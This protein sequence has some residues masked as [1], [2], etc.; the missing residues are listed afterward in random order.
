MNY[1]NLSSSAAVAIATTIRYA[2]KTYDRNMMYDLSY[3]HGG[4]K[5]ITK[6]LVVSGFMRKSERISAINLMPNINNPSCRY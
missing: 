5:R 6:L 2:I 1:R 4:I 3:K